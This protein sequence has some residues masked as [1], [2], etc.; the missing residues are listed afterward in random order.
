[1]NLAIS[2][3]I[4]GIP[5]HTRNQESLIPFIAQVLNLPPEVRSKFS[6]MAILGYW[7]GK[8]HPNIQAICSIIVDELLDMYVNGITIRLKN[9][10]IVTSRTILVHI[11]QDLMMKIALMCMSGPCNQ[12]G[13]DKCEFIGT[14]IQYEKSNGH[15]MKFPCTSLD[16]LGLLRTHDGYVTCAQIA[17]SMRQTQIEALK[18]KGKSDEEIAKNASVNAIQFM[19]IKDETVFTKLPY[20]NV[21]K[22]FSTQAMHC[23]F[24]KYVFK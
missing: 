9:E 18:A 19:G 12:R 21:V 14:S 1:M 17:K 8:G 2:L 3:L 7:I 20:L 13:C 16:N 5:L 24:E 23:I 10:Q 4:D 11:D 6:Y 15:A 22:A